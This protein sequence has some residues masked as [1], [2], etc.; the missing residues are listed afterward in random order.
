[1]E[2]NRNVVVDFIVV[3]VLLPTACLRMSSAPLCC[4]GYKSKIAIT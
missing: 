3:L 4:T 1:M 2:E